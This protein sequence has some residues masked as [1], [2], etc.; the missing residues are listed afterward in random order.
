M[1]PPRDPRLQALIDQFE[2][3]T[4]AQSA[5]YHHAVELIAARQLNATLSTG[6]IV[7]KRRLLSPGRLLRRAF[8]TGG[9]QQRQQG[10]APL[11][12]AATI[13]EGVV[14]SATSSPAPSVDEAETAT[15]IVI[16]VQGTPTGKEDT[17]NG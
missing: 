10:N 5:F 12:R 4:A 8:G 15:V 14:L 6:R 9:R 1:D 13:I 11:Q 2:R 17:Q 7:R 16:N 3:E